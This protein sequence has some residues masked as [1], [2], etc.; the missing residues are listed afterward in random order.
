MAEKTSMI[1]PPVTKPK[2][3][4]QAKEIAMMCNT[5]SKEE[6]GKALHV[7][8]KLAAQAYKRF[9]SFPTDETLPL[10]ALTSY[11]GIVFKH[12]KPNDFTYEDWYFAQQHLLITSFLY[13]LLR[14]LDLI[15]PY[16]LEG[17][18]RLPGFDE[19]SLFTYWKPILTET[20][21]KRIKKEGGI[22]IN[23]ASA[24]MKDLF[25]WKRVNQEVQVITPEFYQLHEGKPKATVIYTKICRG[26][27]TRYII[28]NHINSPEGL[29]D[30]KWEGYCYSP[31]FSQENR[32]SFILA[33]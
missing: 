29:K 4:H 10:P 1:T 21:I 23:L 9:Q 26:E 12:I 3:I 17:N 13:G 18:I 32:L 5:L 8:N 19:Q 27:M 24:E 15:K 14:P 7:T 20:F 22:L 28:K 30:F 33:G 6:L 16:R 11:T 2:F 25:E 31:E